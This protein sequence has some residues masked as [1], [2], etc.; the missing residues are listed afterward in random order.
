M[1][2]GLTLSVSPSFY[3]FPGF[4]K[5]PGRLNSAD[6]LQATIRESVFIDMDIGNRIRQRH[7][8][9]FQINGRQIPQ[10]RYYLSIRPESLNGW[11]NPGLND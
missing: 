7:G 6:C 9:V 4:G 10:R 11:W 3:D 8:S 2:F 5:K 1:I